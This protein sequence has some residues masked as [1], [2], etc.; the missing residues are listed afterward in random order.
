[1]I[2]IKTNILTK[3]FFVSLFSFQLQAEEFYKPDP[4]T[5]HFREEALDAFL[6]GSII[7]FFE[8][9]EKEDP[10]L[11][12][13][14]RTS[15]E[16]E[17][18]CHTYS[19]MKILG[20]DLIRDM[21]NNT[22]SCGQ[23]M[24]VILSQHFKEVNDPQEGDLVAYY[25]RKLHRDPLTHTGI[26]RGNGL[27]ESKWGDTKAIFLHPKFYSPAAWGNEIRYYRQKI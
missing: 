19:S 16:D 26:Y 22:L 15:P 4:T 9:E 17:N 14:S 1:M 2:K 7:D 5:D 18:V 13:I 21:R 12:V 11:K 20:H 3:I 25:N 10:R 6:E 24:E 23:K 8:K 27:V